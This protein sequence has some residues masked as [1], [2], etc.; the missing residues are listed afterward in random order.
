MTAG[1]AICNCDQPDTCL[2]LV[3]VKANGQ[4]YTYEQK[5]EKLPPIIN[6]HDKEGEGVDVDIEI[7]PRGCIGHNEQL[8]PSGNLYLL[9]N[10][11][12]N[13]VERLPHSSAQNYTL[14]YSELPNTQ[15]TL[16]NQYNAVAVLLLLFKDAMTG[17]NNTT[18]NFIVNECKG[19]PLITSG[20]FYN[21]ARLQIGSSI[22][23]FN[24]FVVYPKYSV[25]VGVIIGLKSAIDSL[26]ETQR[27]ELMHAHKL[28]T[29]N[30]NNHHGW[31]AK[32]SSQS[33]TRSLTITGFTEYVCGTQINLRAESDQ[34]VQEFTEYKN[35]LTFLN[36][37]EAAL[38]TASK[39]FATPTKRGADP[40]PI[41]KLSFLSPNLVITGENKFALDKI[42]NQP[43]IEGKVDIALKPLVGIQ[44]T[45]DL[46]QAFAAQYGLDYL[47]GNAREL[48]AS[49]KERISQG[50]NG[51]YIAGELK[52]LIS[53]SINA[54]FGLSYNSSGNKNYYITDKNDAKLSIVGIV[55]I[56][57]GGK[58]LSFEGYFNAEGSVVAEGCCGLEER[59]ATSKG[60]DA[61]LDL[62]FYHNGVKAKFKSNLIFG[63]KTGKTSSPTKIRTNNE[64]I[65]NQS[66][67]TT[68]SN[69]QTG[70]QLVEKTW[71]I[72]KPLAKKNSKHR[73]S[74]T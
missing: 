40:Y 65:T 52:L 54:G 62:V 14:K 46:I 24:R 44:F 31:Q 66:R 49:G 45:V 2:C 73:F 5:G 59:D 29:Y 70:A 17:I 10:E 13:V 22:P 8:C 42:T 34:L 60:D 58:I 16:K 18:Y 53:G 9:E 19:L 50:K 3:E 55:D 51:G 1:T 63:R 23:S 27:K 36:K 48:A 15:I 6:L 12:A 32:T 11:M 47:V 67:S 61:G 33:I 74:I 68:T 72:A 41:G 4:T 30:Y 69:N 25:K 21:G 39:L 43:I 28:S 26:D 56:E 57:A 64:S 38:D 37:A 7:T 71:T 35:K 20:L